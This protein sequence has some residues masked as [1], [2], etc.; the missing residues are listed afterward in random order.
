MHPKTETGKWLKLSMR[1]RIKDKGTKGALPYG[2]PGSV[3]PWLPHVAVLP[4]SGQLFSSW[5]TLAY[6]CFSLRLIL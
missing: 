2:L 6:R 3:R 4:K 1:F 5:R